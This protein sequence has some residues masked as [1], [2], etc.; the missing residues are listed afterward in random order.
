MIDSMDLINDPDVLKLARK[1][2]DLKQVEHVRFWP[3]L[4]KTFVELHGD[5]TVV[6]T[7]MVKSVD[8]TDENNLYVGFWK[9]LSEKNYRDETIHNSI[10]RDFITE[11]VEYKETGKLNG[12]K[13]TH[14]YSPYANTEIFTTQ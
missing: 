7:C 11:F 4:K 2:K 12:V 6:F 9:I 10:I 1:L 5:K 13:T 14:K 3:A 8:Y